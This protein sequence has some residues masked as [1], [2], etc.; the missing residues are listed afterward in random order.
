[1]SFARFMNL[2]LYSPGIG[3]Y[4]AGSVKL[5]RDGDFI[6]A[7]E[8]SDLFSECVARQCAQVLSA[9]GGSILELGAGSG[10]MAAAILESLLRQDCLPERYYILEVSADLAQ[11]QRD[12]VQ[13]LPSALRA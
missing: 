7:P 6:T 12:R 8:M 3:Y 11:R 9:T 10:R 4:S 1:M 2:A 5:G 13:S